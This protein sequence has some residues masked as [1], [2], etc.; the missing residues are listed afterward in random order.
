MHRQQVH[1]GDA[2]ALQVGDARVRGQA[3]VAAALR[4]GHAGVQLAEAAHMHFVQHAVR[5]GRGRRDITLPVE[6]F[7][8]HAGLQR[9]GAVVA[10]VH[11]QRVVVG[12]AAVRIAPL[13]VADHLARIGVEQQLVR[14]EALPVLRLPRPVGTQSVDEAGAGSGQVA[15]PDIAAACRQGQARGLDAPRIVV[16]AKLDGHGMR[17]EHGEVHALGIDAGAQRPGLAGPQR[18]Q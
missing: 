13:E 18:R 3:G 6:L 9:Q 8:H 15:M 11:A 7:V 17:R 1:G 14:V 16:Q 5:P 12:L 10:K 4:L 2:Q